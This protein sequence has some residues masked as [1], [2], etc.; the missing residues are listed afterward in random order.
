VQYERY[1]T[2]AAMRVAFGTSALTIRTDHADLCAQGLA[3]EWTWR[4][5]PADAAP[6]GTYRCTVQADG[7]RLDWTTDSLRTVGRAIRADGDLHELH[8]WWAAA[9]PD[10]PAAAATEGPA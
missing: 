7:A 9:G 5:D 8:G 6:A 3:D 4:A 2:V 1:A 10:A